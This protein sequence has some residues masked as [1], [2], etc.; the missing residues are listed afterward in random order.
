MTGKRNGRRALRRFTLPHI[1]RCG[2]Q[3]R[4]TFEPRAPPEPGG[5]DPHPAI[6]DAEGA[7]QIREGHLLICLDC[8]ARSD[9]RVP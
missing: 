9:R 2:A 1:C 6:V 8:G 4:V 7:F 5:E 3:G